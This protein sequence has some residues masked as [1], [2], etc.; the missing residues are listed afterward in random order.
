MFSKPSLL[1]RSITA[2]IFGLAFGLFC[3]YLINWL[4]LNVSFVVQF[5]LILWCI[6]LGGLVALIGV[7][8][9]LPQLKASLPSWFSG[10]F[11]C[12]W[13]NLLLWLIGGD[14]LTSIGQGIFPTLGSLLLGV[15]FVVIG[16]AFGVVAGFFATLIGGEGAG[17][18]R[19]YTADK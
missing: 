3:I 17:V 15:G 16:F 2:K 12:G 19:D 1:K 14:S 5:G 7:I 6:T 8:N 10:G 13:M 18:A 4:N 9:Y 11:I